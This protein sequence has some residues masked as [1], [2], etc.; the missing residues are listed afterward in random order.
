MTNLTEK[1]TDLARLLFGMSLLFAPFTF[2]VGLSFHVSGDH[3]T[4]SQMIDIAQFF[5]IIGAAG[6]IIMDHR[7][8][9]QR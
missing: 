7:N 5:A 1:L 8:Q 2:F 6:A 9:R 3:E 4:A